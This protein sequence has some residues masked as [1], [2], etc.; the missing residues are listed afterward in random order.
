MTKSPRKPKDIRDIFNFLNDLRSNSI[1]FRLG[2]SRDDSVSLDFT[3]VGCRVEVDFFD[4][5]IEFSYFT[6]DE[7]VH[8]D[9]AIMQA[10]LDKHW[11]DD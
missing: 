7:S 10:L 3:L 6:G 5:H 11:N 1:E 8:S 2:S 4:D 9:W